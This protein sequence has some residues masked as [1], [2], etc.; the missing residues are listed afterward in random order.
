MKIFVLANTL[1]FKSVIS[2]GDIVLPQIAKFW[3]G[4]YDLHVITGKLGMDTWKLLG[5]EAEFH[6]VP[7][8]FF[9]GSENLVFAPLKYI[10]RMIYAVFLLDRLVSA[11]KGPC[12]IYTSSDLFPD[13]LPAA[14]VRRK[15]MHARW[16]ARI[17]HVNKP[18]HRRRGNVFYN[19]FSFLAQRTGFFYI[20]KYS[21]AV[22]ALVGSLKDLGSLGFPME[23][24]SVSNAGVDISSI[25]QVGPS[26]DRFDA[27]H[28]G[29]L[30]YT[31]GVYD[32]LD[33]WKMIAGVRKE[34]RL[35]IIGGASEALMNDY[36][37]RIREMGLLNNITYFGFVPRNEDVYSVIKSSRIY[38]C[39]GHENGWSLPVTEAMAAGIPVAAYNLQMFGTAFMK[40][41][42][43]AD[44]YDKKGLSTI[45]LRLL[46][47]SELWDRLSKE[48]L[49]ESQ[50]FGWQSVSDGLMA[51]IDSIFR[52]ENQL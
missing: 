38:I 7:E 4:K 24:V 12:L 32:L 22:S 26:S 16:I 34:A 50:K 14:W 49:E 28:V 23:K 33:I 39:P 27:V 40:G 25:R 10:A 9:K 47:D 37:K 11:E 6:T 31:K 19:L 30:T 13:A 43:T 46:D 48:A 42:M 8:I 20:K 36:R 5:A 21:D 3:K 41:Y 35:A 2:G 15:H 51:V 45:I 17:Y 52:G 1:L 44:L 29:T 18:P